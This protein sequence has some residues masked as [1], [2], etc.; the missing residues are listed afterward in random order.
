MI[1]GE[2]KFAGAFDFDFEDE[3]I[4]VISICDNDG[5]VDTVGGVAV[6]AEVAGDEAFVEE[7]IEQFRHLGWADCVQGLLYI[8]A[9]YADGSFMLL[10]LL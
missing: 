8:R 10:F 1:L 4:G 7:G 5:A 6:E 3:G 9:F 2:N